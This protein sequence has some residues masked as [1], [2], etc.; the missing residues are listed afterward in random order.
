MV[1]VTDLGTCLGLG[2]LATDDYRACD[3]HN[4]Q[5]NL[6]EKMI[7]GMLLWV[8]AN[9]IFVVTRKVGNMELLR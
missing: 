5:H 4:Y 3:P 1:E 7:Q 2:F 8:S 6:A 9:K